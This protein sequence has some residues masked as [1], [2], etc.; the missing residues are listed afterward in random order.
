MLVEV[1]IFDIFGAEF[2]YCVVLKE[3]AG[4]RILD[5]YIS[6]ISVAQLLYFIKEESIKFSEKIFRPLTHNLLINIINELGAKIQRIIIH[7][8]ENNIYFADIILGT[9]QGDKKIDCRPSDGLALSLICRC[10]VFVESNLMKTEEDVK[11]ELND[12]LEKIMWERFKNSDHSD[13]IM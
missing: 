6:P 4:K 2:Q 13:E 12:N 7:K 10:P 1:E 11:R 3:K 9:K 8:L 5:L